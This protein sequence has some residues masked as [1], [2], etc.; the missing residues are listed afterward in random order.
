MTHKKKRY[1]AWAQSKAQHGGNGGNGG[2]WGLCR[3]G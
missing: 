3:R 2:F 1:A